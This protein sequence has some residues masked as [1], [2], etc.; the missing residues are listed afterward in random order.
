MRAHLI[1][2]D[3]TQLVFICMAYKHLMKTSRGTACFFVFFFCKYV[4]GYKCHNL[5]GRQKL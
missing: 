5:D 1:K 4:G 2:H 3:E